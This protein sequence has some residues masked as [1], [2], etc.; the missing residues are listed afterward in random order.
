MVSDCSETLH[1]LWLEGEDTWHTAY[2]MIPRT[3]RGDGRGDG[4]GW[5]LI[6]PKAPLVFALHVRAERGRS[7]PARAIN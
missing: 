6:A 7:P 5:H 4:Q 3:R 1:R 2:D